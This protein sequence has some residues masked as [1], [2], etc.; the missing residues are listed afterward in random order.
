MTRTS[1]HIGPQSI[2]GDLFRRHPAGE[3]RPARVRRCNEA[4]VDKRGE[5]VLYWMISARRTGWNFAL[6]RAIG[7][8]RE[9]RL[10]LLVFE[11]PA[12]RLSLGV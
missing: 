10:P 5:Y 2:E 9:L 4:P 8:C 1:E 11:P 3:I 7:H 12:R 6:E